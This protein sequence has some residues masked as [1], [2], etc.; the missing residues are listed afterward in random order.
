MD[1][2]PDTVK[3]P[4]RRSIDVIYRRIKAR[5]GKQLTVT[6]ETV[7]ITYFTEYHSA[8]DVT[9]TRNGHDN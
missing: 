4:P 2:N 8:V 1:K 6:G 9:D 3:K 7:N 5:K